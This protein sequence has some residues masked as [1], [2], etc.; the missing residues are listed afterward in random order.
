M[1]VFLLRSSDRPTAPGKLFPFRLGLLPKSGEGQ[2]PLQ[3]TPHHC[4]AIEEEGKRLAPCIAKP[5]RWCMYNT[6]CVF[7]RSKEHIRSK[8][9]TN[10]DKKTRWKFFQSNNNRESKFNLAG[11]WEIIG[12][13]IKKLSGNCTVKNACFQLWKLILFI[14]FWPKSCLEQTTKLFS[15]NSP[16]TF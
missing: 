4:V 15:G 2:C 8:V 5:R 9:E 1:I 10:F 6:F 12:N 11:T 7:E 13:K 14:L 3:L 16:R